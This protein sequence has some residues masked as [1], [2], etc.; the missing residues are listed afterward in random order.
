VT[1]DLRSVSERFRAT[2]AQI[3]DAEDLPLDPWLYRYCGS[4]REVSG[5]E[6]YVRHQADLLDLAGV[7]SEHPVI[8]DAGCGF[9]FAMI[10]HALLGAERIEGIEVHE[11][12]VSTVKAYLAILPDDVSGRIQVTRG[13]VTEMPY[14]DE[15][16]DVVLSVEAISHY[17]DV[18][19]FLR[20]ARRV[21]RP[22]G[23]LIVADGN[24]G[25]N[26]R[27]RRR[28]GEIWEAFE[29]GPSG[30][31][32]GGH[33]VGVP[34]VDRRRQALDENFPSLA[35]DVRAQIASRTAGYTDERVLAAAGRYAESG[36]LPD[37]PYRRG[38]LAIAPDGQAMERLF[39]PASLA[40]QI[41]ESGFHSAKALGYW[42]GASGSP[43][44]RQVN[45]ALSAASPVTLPFA[46][47]FRVVAHK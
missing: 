23:A 31:Q 38:Q 9:G 28:A 24:N 41:A 8:V 43:M 40:R 26:P 18:P 4:T 11:G 30:R 46:P 47:S 14:E 29:K 10:V 13:S 19:A 12:M 22:G 44:V 5:A 39:S 21:L 42:G 20:E 35:D 7:R 45:R 1:R 37:S 17:L 34:Y 2:V 32:I 36:V 33:V 15:S 25:S 27:T 16:A 3:L 6:R